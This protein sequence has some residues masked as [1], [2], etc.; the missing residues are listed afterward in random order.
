MYDSVEN[1][2]RGGE[3]I[4]PM[5]ETPSTETPEKKLAILGHTKKMIS[6]SGFFINKNMR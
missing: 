4:Y 2:R 1:S 6:F 5:T 3:A